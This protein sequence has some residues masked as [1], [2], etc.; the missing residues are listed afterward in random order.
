VSDPTEFL[1]ETIPNLFNEGN[2]EV[3]S[4]ADKGDAE[5]K[6]KREEALA[7]APFAIR[8]VLE[9]K[10][11]KDLYVVSEKGELRTVESAPAGVPVL[12]AFALPEEAF[13]LALDD[14]KEDL[15]K[16]LAKLRKRIPQLSPARARAGFER[17]AQ[18]QL[19]FHFVMKDTPDFEEVR[20]KI[21]IGDKEPP[22]KPTFTVTLDYDVFEQLRSRKLKPQALVS[23]LQLAGD[24]SRA[25][26]LIM[27][28]VQ[29]RGA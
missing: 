9:G 18:E 12:F 13:E 28:A 21:A 17:A 25:M 24:S 8:V 27:Q 19:R 23:K 15:D 3:R 29:R 2:A 7:A 22:E 6:K 14:M 20:V 10:A 11:K 26:Q 1:K 4:A 16:A 5:A